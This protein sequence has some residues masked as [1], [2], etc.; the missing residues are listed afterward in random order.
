MDRDSLVYKAKLAEQA[1]RFDE[2]VQDMYVSLFI[3]FDGR[4]LLGIIVL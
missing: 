4:L 1:E 3:V 2:M